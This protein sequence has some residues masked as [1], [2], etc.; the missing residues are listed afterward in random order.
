MQSASDGSA[1][2][3]ATLADV[4]ESVGQSLLAPVAAPA[5]LNVSVGPPV[6]FDPAD[7]PPAEPHAVLLLAGLRPHMPELAASI[8]AAAACGAAAVVVKARGEATDDLAR[9]ADA[10]RIAALVA[11]DETPWERIQA[12]L[13]TAIN[14]RLGGRRSSDVRAAANEDLL[15]L[16]NATARARRRRRHDRGRAAHDHGLLEPRGP[17][18]RSHP[19]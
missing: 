4:L 14:G 3:Q 12:M 19:P 1:Q 5:G 6:I 7:E 16:A 13:A 8:R 18:D 2:G 15:L 10:A 17:A 9:R 11:P